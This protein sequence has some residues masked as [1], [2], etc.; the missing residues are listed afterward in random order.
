MQI[1]D[2][3]LMFYGYSN[4]YLTTAYYL[5][6]LQSGD[7]SEIFSELEFFI[8]GS[9]LAIQKI[10][11]RNEGEYVYCG[12]IHFSHLITWM[13]IKPHFANDSS[14][15]SLTLVESR[16]YHN[17]PQWDPINLEVNSKY[18]AVEALAREG[19]QVPRILLYSVLKGPYVWYSISLKESAVTQIEVLSFILVSMNNKTVII[20]AN[21]RPNSNL[22]MYYESRPMI[23]TIAKAPTLDNFNKYNLVIGDRSLNNSIPL[24]Y[25]LNYQSPYQQ[26]W[27]HFELFMLVFGGVALLTLAT[28][29]IFK[30]SANNTQLPSKMTVR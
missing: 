11:C 2:K 13:Q 7:P 4:S 28:V 8:R 6:N 14:I 16:V 20:V 9:R 1:D 22:L 24:R 21:R 10:V 26:S 3:C 30:R 29:A 15:S 25:L 27:F 12:V 23:L 19:G 17:H 5:H 18:I